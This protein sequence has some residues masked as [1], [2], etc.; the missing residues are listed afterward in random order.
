MQAGA[1]GVLSTLWTV[2]DLSTGLLMRRFYRNRFDL[3]LK[4]PAALREAQA[5][6]RG[7]TREDASRVLRE[8]GRRAESRDDLLGPR[9]ENPYADPYF[10]AAFTYNGV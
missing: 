8:Q 7:L 1:S 6:L 9:E 5:W 3:G 2:D 10:W 4:G